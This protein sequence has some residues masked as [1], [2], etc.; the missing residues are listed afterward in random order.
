MPKCWLRPN[1]ATLG[2]TQT[3]LVLLS[4]ARIFICIPTW[5]RVKLHSAILGCIRHRSSE[6]DTLPSLAREVKCFS[7][8]LF[9]DEMRMPRFETPSFYFHDFDW[10]S[11]HFQTHYSVADLYQGDADC[12]CRNSISTLSLQNQDHLLWLISVI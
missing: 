9:C 8:L 5:L 6:L 3:S 1:S 12:Q 4:F 7:T 10:C 11:F 2:I